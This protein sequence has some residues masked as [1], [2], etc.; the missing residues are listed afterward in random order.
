MTSVTRLSAPFTPQ[1]ASGLGLVDNSTTIQIEVSDG[2]SL[3]P[4]Y[5]HADENPTV[6]KSKK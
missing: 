2:T 4:P 3:F 1:P 6:Y 5:Q